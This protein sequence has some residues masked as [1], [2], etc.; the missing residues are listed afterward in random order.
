M[1]FNYKRLAKSDSYKTVN[2]KPYK[3]S[4]SSVKAL[5]I[6][7]TGGT[8][9][10]AKNEC[11]FF[12]LRNTR[13]AGAHSFVDYNGLTGRSIYPSFVAWSVG[14]RA[15]G[16]GTFYGKYNNF[17]TISIELCGIADKDISAKQLKALKKVIRYY[18]RKCPNIDNII[19]HY[20]V[21]T[22]ICP[23]RYCN[24]TSNDKK[25]KALRSEL[26]IELKKA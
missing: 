19:R 7:Y 5:V 23:S 24:S 11:D 18:K 25:W 15:N 4:L 3:R 2:G 1:I 20:D 22:K 9:D 21:T 8:R 13:S 6:H 17:N 12:A 10:T 26:M 16:H 14:D